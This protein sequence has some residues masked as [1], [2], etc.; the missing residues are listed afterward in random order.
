MHLDSDEADQISEAM[1]EVGLHPLLLNDT[2]N[3]AVTSKSFLSVATQ[4]RVQEPFLNP[5][6]SFSPSGPPHSPCPGKP[7]SLRWCNCCEMTWLATGEHSKLEKWTTVFSKEY[8]EILCP[9]MFA[10]RPD[11]RDDPAILLRRGVII[12][13][14][15]EKKF[16]RQLVTQW[17]TKQA[18]AEADT[19]PI[20]ASRGRDVLQSYRNFAFRRAQVKRLA[21]AAVPP[22]H[23]RSQPASD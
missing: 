18:D 17:F 12:P 14:H 22:R 16:R 21:Y 5:Q 8:T 4:V 20:P 11:V 13:I 9:G 10:K 3:L 6:A 7:K 23:V 1:S 15:P 2:M 19:K